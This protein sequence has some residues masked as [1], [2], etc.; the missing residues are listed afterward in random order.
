[1]SFQKNLWISHSALSSFSRCPR[2]Y[3]L[4][5]LYRNPDTGRRIQIINPYLSLG[6]AVHETIEGLIDVPI[7]KRK[8]ISLTERFSKI[9]ENYSGLEGGFISSKKEEEFKE[10]GVRMVERVEKSSFL[11]NPSTGLDVDFPSIN[12]IGDDIKLVGSIDWVE[13]LPNGGAHII[14]FKTGNSKESNDSLQLPIYFILA[15]NNLSRKVEKVSYWYLEHDNHPSSREINDLDSYIEILKEKAKEIKESIDKNDFP[16]SYPGR[17]F[18][19]GDYNKIFQGEAD[20]VSVNNNH[21]KDVFCVFKEKEVV[22]KVL[23]DDFLDER[24]KKIFEM[25]MDFPMEVIMKELRIS[26]EKNEKIVNEIKRK[27][28]NNLRPKELKIIVNLLSK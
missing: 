15:K 23:E 24:E 10:R 28:K 11:E 18:S 1:M 22:E 21:K 19:C 7:N 13:I 2:Q 6:S 5:Y 25:R 26:E 8:N 12:L 17:C 20:L 4:E 14:D 16:C 27:L 3:Y 9:F